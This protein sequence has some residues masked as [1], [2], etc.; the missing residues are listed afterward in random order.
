MSEQVVTKRTYVL[1]W[2]ALM[3]L[4]GL[5]A[6]ISFVNLAQW[7]T[8]VALL[9]AV[10]KAVLVALFFMHLLYEKDK[11]VWIWAGVGMFWLGIMIIMTMGDYVTR[12][13]L[14]V[15]GK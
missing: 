7:S 9:I 10:A 15:P 4:T 6:G 8:V 2:V 3:C 11:I 13:F 1:V 14:R 12:G 5:T